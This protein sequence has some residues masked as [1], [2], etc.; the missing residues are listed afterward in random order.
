MNRIHQEPRDEVRF[1]RAGFIFATLFRYRDD[2]RKKKVTGE[3]KY[4]HKHKRC[5]YRRTAPSSTPSS[6]TLSLKYREGTR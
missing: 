4:R 2:L 5:R 3:H 1:L 6:H